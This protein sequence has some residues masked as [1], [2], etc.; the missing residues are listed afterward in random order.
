MC[1][2]LC[3][4]LSC[5][6]TCVLVLH[7]S[8]ALYTMCTCVFWAW[9]TCYLWKMSVNEPVSVGTGQG[10]PAWSPYIGNWCCSQ[11]VKGTGSFRSKGQRR[12]GPQ[13]C[14]TSKTRNNA[15]LLLH[16]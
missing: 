11:V 3:L 15:H 14:L 6:L 7:K 10:G 13:A 12:L 8:R 16:L 4:L 9:T 1:L 2:Q 5:V